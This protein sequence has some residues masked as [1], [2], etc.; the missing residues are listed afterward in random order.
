MGLQH[1]RSSSATP[2][3]ARPGG[4]ETAGALCCRMEWCISDSKTKQKTCGQERVPSGRYVIIT[5]CAYWTAYA[6]VARVCDLSRCLCVFVF[7][8]VGRFEQ[9]RASSSFEF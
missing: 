7:V 3:K 8:F 4:T 1:S 5:K 6:Y 2:K 9:T